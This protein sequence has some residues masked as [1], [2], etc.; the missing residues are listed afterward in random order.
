MVA[1][2]SQLHAR[3]LVFVWSLIVVVALYYVNFELLLLPAP[4]AYTHAATSTAVL[5]LGGSLFWF[6]PPT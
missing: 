5:V 1:G 4:E 6:R 3:L 2:G